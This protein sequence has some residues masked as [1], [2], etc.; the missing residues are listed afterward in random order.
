[1]HQ[2]LYRKW[3][4]KTFEEVCG[5]QH[6]TDILKYEVAENL[7]SHAYLF[8]GSRGTGKT[9]CAKILA[10][11]VNCENPQNGNPC[12]AC[13]SCLAAASGA[14]TDILEMDAASNNKVDDIRTILD[15][16][17]YTPSSLKYRVYIIDEVHML[18][19]SAFN[20]LLKTLEEPPEHVIFILA[21]TEM[22]KLPATI[23]SR[24]QR[25]DFRRIQ[26]NILVERLKY[27]A[28]EENIR[29]DDDA[30]LI[31]A[32]L[33]QG[34]MRDAISLFELSA[35]GG[36]DVTAD[37]VSEAVGFTG[38]G[39]MSE[40]VRAIASRNCSGLLDII[41]R[42][43]AS[44]KD[45]GV[46]WQELIGYYRD[47]LVFRTV[48]KE[49]AAGYLDLTDTESS[50]I[51]ADSAMFS[52]EQLI[53]H[54]KMLDDAY[55]AMQRPGASSRI[56]AETALLRMTDE[57][58]SVSYEALLSRIAAL[59]AGMLSGGFTAR[60]KAETPEKQPVSAPK[61]ASEAI[62]APARDK[63]AAGTQRP[64]AEP[65]SAP[66]AVPADERVRLDC[67]QEVLETLRKTNS[68]VAALLGSTEAFRAESGA[69]LRIYVIYKAEV[70]KRLATAPET[71]GNF[72]AALSSSLGSRIDPGMIV[73]E[74][75]GSAPGDQ[76][77]KGIA[78]LD[79][80]IGK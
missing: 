19:V 5:Q 75:A 65:V 60:E 78:E 3:R 2:A 28:G 53:Y 26:T 68:G 4:P 1:M 16:V 55:T 57:K 64:S 25:F 15:E 80:L 71:I 10:K 46:F 74:K 38:R 20:A 18:S 29:L 32:R 22:Q 8:C 49:A 56:C 43:T 12:L 41:S 6:V 42:V 11:A 35:V 40:C 48:G 66:T 27:I 36:K 30:A 7:V 79:A 59:E 62:P 50:M 31:L 24:C 13:R 76:V 69:G 45:I 51:A 34:G 63:A 58:L 73:F 61:T 23:I 44:A 39:P 67:W 9:T 77:R 17:I 37:T 14:A 33:A 47:M 72:C 70:A 21:T 54:S 52:R